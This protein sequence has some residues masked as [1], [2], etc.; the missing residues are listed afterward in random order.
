M[1][2]KDGIARF[3]QRYDKAGKYT[4][5]ATGSIKNALTGQTETAKKDYTFEVFPK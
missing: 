3:S 1:D 5:T 2:I 4:I